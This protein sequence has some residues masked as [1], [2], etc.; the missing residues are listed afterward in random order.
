MYIYIYIYIHIYSVYT[1]YTF[2]NKKFTDTKNLAIIYLN[3]PG[4]PVRKPF[5]SRQIVE[6]QL[7]V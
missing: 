7:D 1:I 6:E 4:I 3:V 5:E 2:S